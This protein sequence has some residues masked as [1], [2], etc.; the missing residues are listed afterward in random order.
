LNTLDIIYIVIMVVSFAVS[1]SRGGVRELFSLMAVGVGFV[2]ASRFYQF[3]AGQLLR[4]T[5]HEEVNNII[6]FTIIFLFV[7]ILV[8]Y[9]GQQLTHIVKKADL[10][11]WN[12]ITGSAIGLVKG[13]FI[14][15]LL[16]YMLLVFMKPGGGFFSGSKAFPLMSELT[17][18]VSPIGPKN[19][20]DE[21][22]KKLTGL[23]GE[24][25]ESATPPKKP[26]SKPATPMPYP[27][28]HMPSK[29]SQPSPETAR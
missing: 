10:G 7:A 17:V 11:F 20:R 21:L 22:G 13:L 4:L 29:A 27:P 5:S 6:S 2:A 9:V 23:F 8:S 1:A 28:E 16:T 18:A 26:S 24:T 25:A 12:I 14:C 3:G 15:A 19:F